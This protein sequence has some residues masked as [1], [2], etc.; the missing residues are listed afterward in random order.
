[1]VRSTAT[2]GMSG[3]CLFTQRNI[4][5]HDAVAVFD[6]VFMRGE[7]L[8]V[9]TGEGEIFRQEGGQGAPAISHET[10]GRRS[11]WNVR[12]DAIPSRPPGCRSAGSEIRTV[13]ISV[14]L[15]ERSA[16]PLCDRAVKAVKPVINAIVAAVERVDWT[17]DRPRV[18][19]ESC[20]LSAWPESAGRYR[21][22][23][24]RSVLHGSTLHRWREGLVPMIPVPVFLL[25]GRVRVALF[26]TG[27]HLMATRTAIP[28]DAPGT[29]PR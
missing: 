25:G 13:S 12:D 8:V 5:D 23:A 20:V 10:Q 19:A 9:M 15:S 24:E 11:N 22:V 6:R 21:I 3:Q 16:H 28:A 4:A 27:I 2:P 29:L 17:R 14:G 18:S 26:S 1:M 7:F